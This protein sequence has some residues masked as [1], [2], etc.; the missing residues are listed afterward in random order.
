MEFV[1]GGLFVA[2]IWF[3]LSTKGKVTSA[4]EFILRQAASPWFKAPGFDSSTLRYEWYH[5]PELVRNFNASVVVGVGDRLGKSTGFCLEVD[6]AKG[7][8]AELLISTNVVSWHRDAA[9][10]AREHNQSLIGTMSTMDS[11]G[12]HPFHQFILK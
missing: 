6:G 7:V 2:A 3:Y 4:N 5:S 12:N 11:I 8:V 1:I 10:T 9:K